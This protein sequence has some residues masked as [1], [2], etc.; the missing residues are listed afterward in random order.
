MTTPLAANKPA[1]EASSLPSAA[2]VEVEIKFRVADADALAARLL[3]L[4]FQLLT[5]STHEYNRLFDTPERTLR[6]AGQ[7]LRIRKYGDQYV[8]THKAPLAGKPDAPHKHRVETETTLADGEALAQV[9]ASLGFSVTFV[10]E[11]WR[12]EY[13][14]GTGHLVI[15][16]TPI[17]SFA[18]LEGPAE[19]IDATAARL[20]VASRDYMTASYAKLFVE[21]RDATGNTAQNMTRAEVAAGAL[22]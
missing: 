5:P 20:G 12:A 14:D 19:W 1:A 15:D 4:G 13:S 11:K 9:F 8:L 21:W 17:G 7:T 2:K 18:E 3:A 10:Y 6:T 16:E 22:R